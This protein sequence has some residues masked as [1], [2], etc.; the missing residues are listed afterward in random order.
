[1]SV[2]RFAES[3]DKI[4]SNHRGLQCWTELKHHSRQKN[5]ALQRRTKNAVKVSDQQ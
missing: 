3:S 4:D 1:M 2:F 5:A